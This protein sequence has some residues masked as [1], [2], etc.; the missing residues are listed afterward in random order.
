MCGCL[1]ARRGPL[2]AFCVFPR[3]H[4]GPTDLPLDR[5][6][7]SC[8]VATPR[9]GRLGPAPWLLTAGWQARS[10]AAVLALVAPEWQGSRRSPR[11]SADWFA[12]S[13]PPW[14]A[15]VPPSSPRPPS[16]SSGSRRRGAWRCR[17]SRRSR[18]VPASAPGRG[19]KVGLAPAHK[20]KEGQNSR[21]GLVTCHITKNGP[22][23]SQ[24]GLSPGRGRWAWA[25]PTCASGRSQRVSGRSKRA[26]PPSRS[27]P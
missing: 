18:G 22:E 23:R 5:A 16:V 1:V 4:V 21:R 9:P 3:R 25:R 12:N 8:S 14:P 11:Y 2:A 27:S 26:G 24:P 15:P 13:R 7:S 10:M 19:G 17:S 6:P 20:K